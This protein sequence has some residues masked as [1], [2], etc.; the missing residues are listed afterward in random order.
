MPNG[1]PS[2]GGGDEHDGASNEWTALHD[3]DPER[4]RST[5][6]GD[7]D[8][9]SGVRKC[10][11]MHDPETELEFVSPDKCRV[12]VTCPKC[13]DRTLFY[14]RWRSD[15]DERYDEE[16]PAFGKLGSTETG[17]HDTGPEP[18]DAD[19]DNYD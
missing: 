4:S 12:E 1:N 5:F 16:H 7:P 13:T 18:D 2:G 17:E 9:P 14:T 8:P 11:L 19:G 6:E 3:D 15:G 10:L